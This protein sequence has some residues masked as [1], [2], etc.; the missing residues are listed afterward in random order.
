MRLFVALD[1]PDAV[2]GALGELIAQLKLRCRAARWA[3]PEGMHVTLKFIGHAIDRTEVE[4][5][6]SARAALA[7]VRAGNPVDLHFRGVGFFPDARRPRVLWC[8]VQASENLAPLAADIERALEPLGIPPEGRAFVPHLTL[9]RL[10]SP[11]G[12]AQLVRLASAFST[13]DFGSA[14]EREFHL[15][16]SL[17]KPSGAEYKK[18]ETYR[19]VK[20]AA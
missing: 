14:S 5:L 1:L 10:K 20:D 11:E 16:E 18:I 7:S 13:R 8:G 3:R 15:F 6:D 19:F 12:A 4:K 9:A 17:L 2:R